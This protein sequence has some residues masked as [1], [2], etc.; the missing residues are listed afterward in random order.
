MRPITDLSLVRD[1]ADYELHL[2]SLSYIAILT[3]FKKM[4][5]DFIS[6]ITCFHSRVYKLPLC[7]DTVFS[8]LWAGHSITPTDKYNNC[9]SKLT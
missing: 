9:R 5:A 6:F 1:L 8:T 2:L 4:K 3:E 7:A